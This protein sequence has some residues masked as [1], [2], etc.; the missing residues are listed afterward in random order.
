ML[1]EEAGCDRLKFRGRSADNPTRRPSDDS[2]Y[3]IDGMEK[4]ARRGQDR[5][6]VDPESCLGADRRGDA[7][8]RGQRDLPVGQAVLDDQPGGGAL[9]ARF[10]SARAA[11]GD[12]HHSN[13]A[14]C[15]GAAD[16]PRRH[17]GRPV[18]THTTAPDRGARDPEVAAPAT[19][20]S[21]CPG[22]GKH[23]PRKERLLLQFPS[24]GGFACSCHRGPT[25]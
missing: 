11:D 15:L 9:P 3:S 21:V 20:E 4:T 16:R 19:T 24:L 8:D 14:F 6:R 23:R 12:S 1:P 22:A 10:P 25:S 18:G 17:P 2:Y 7:R 13:P 5:G